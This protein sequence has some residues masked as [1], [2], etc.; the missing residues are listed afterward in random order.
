MAT[1]SNT[2]SIDGGMT[3]PASNVID[4][5]LTTEYISGTNNAWI[6]LTF[7]A[8]VMISA[9]RLHA[10]A[11]PETVEIYSL[12]TS[13]ST[14]PL[15]RASL[16]VKMAPGGVLPD[17]QVTPGLYSNITISI[18]GGASWVGVDEVWLLAAPACP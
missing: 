2:L 14:V 11:L 3:Y 13:T 9:I 16:P 5:D 7:P 15:G 17:I 12:S 1:A 6:T 4:G 18:D 10:D 8:P